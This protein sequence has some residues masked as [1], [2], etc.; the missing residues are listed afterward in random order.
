MNQWDMVRQS[1][2][3]AH[4]DFFS[5]QSR[6]NAT[7]YNYS[8][9]S[10][11]SDA[12]EITGETRN[13]FAT[14][15]SVEIVPPG[16]DS[17]VDSDGTSFGWSTSIRFPQDEFDDSKIVPLGEDNERP[18]EVEL[19]NQKDS[20]TETFELHSYTT[21]IGSGMIMCRLVEQ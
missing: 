13:S 15:V 4:D 19:T 11:D 12:D 3:R 16:Q 8:G 10:W 21:E 9:G 18:T 20:S 5:G 2:G 6:Y 1:F 14:D 17:T 7:F